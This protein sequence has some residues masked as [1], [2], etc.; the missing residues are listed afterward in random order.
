MNRNGQSTM[1]FA[2][3]IAVLVAALIAIQI[4]MKRGIM[5]KLRENTEQI[6]A[7]FEP[8]SA[9]WNYTTKIN[10]TQNEGLTSAGVQTTTYTGNGV[11]QIK[12]GSEGIDANLADEQLF[13]KKAP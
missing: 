6:G 2:L 9:T 4:F 5:G 13:F 11:T 1:E 12:T 3:L 7:Q 8:H 10:G